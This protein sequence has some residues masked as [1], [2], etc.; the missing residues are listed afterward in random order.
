MAI[1]DKARARAAA[2]PPVPAARVAAKTGQGQGKKS[3]GLMDALSKV[4]TQP[5]PMSQ[6]AKNIRNRNEYE[7]MEEGLKRK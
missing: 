7:K 2:L 6:D 5:A 4:G 1:R 3:G